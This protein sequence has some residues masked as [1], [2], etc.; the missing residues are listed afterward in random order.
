MRLII[1]INLHHPLDLPINYHHILQGVI[2]KGLSNHK[3][4]SAF[5][6][7]EGYLY[8]KRQFKMFTF[9]NLEG[10]YFIRNK[11]ICF[12]DVVKW[13]IRSPEILFIQTL[14]ASFQQEGISFREDTYKD[15]MITLLDDEIEDDDIIVRMKMPICLYSTEPET[16]KMYFY[17]PDEIVFYQLLE[18]NFARKYQACYGLTPEEDIEVL[19]VEVHEKDKYVTRYKNLY[20]SGWKGIYR[21]RGKRK[22]LNFLYATGLGS[23][24]SQGFGMFEVI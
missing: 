6:H 14:A 11:R 4:Y 18:D 20:I 24:N 21:I 2:Y 22:Y 16:K 3:G 23:K 5:V 13:E 12:E 9:S 8:E 1:H 15:L 7:N 10:K 19:P 17:R